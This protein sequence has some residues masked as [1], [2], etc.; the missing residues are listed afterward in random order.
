MSMVV[1]VGGS[2]QSVVLNIMIGVTHSV[3]GGIYVPMLML[4][5]LLQ[6]GYG[7]WEYR[8]GQYKSPEDNRVDLATID[9]EIISEYLKFN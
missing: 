7:I 9:P 2:V 6:T 4:T 5:V 8:K 3:A 1:S